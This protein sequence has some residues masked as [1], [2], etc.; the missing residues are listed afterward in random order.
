MRSEKS[1]S[2]EPAE[3]DALEEEIALV[4]IQNRLDRA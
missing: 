1:D 4:N 2:P 3:R